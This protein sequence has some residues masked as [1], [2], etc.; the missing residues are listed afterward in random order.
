[1][2]SGLQSAHI[3][4]LFCI[5]ALLSSFASK[6]LQANHL[7]SHKGRLLRILWLSFTKYQK[8]LF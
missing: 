5:R 6:L 4:F 2:L 8:H 3:V 7:G 1:M